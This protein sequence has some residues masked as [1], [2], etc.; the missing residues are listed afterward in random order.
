MRSESKQEIRCAICGIEC[1]GKLQ[2]RARENFT[3]IVCTSCFNRT[4]L[5]PMIEIR[6]LIRD[7]R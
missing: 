1:K 6:K 4:E 5:L 3:Y 7:R 2:V